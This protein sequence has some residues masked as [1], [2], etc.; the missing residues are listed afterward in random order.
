MGFFE[1]YREKKKFKNNLMI[2]RIRDKPLQEHVMSIIYSNQNN[3]MNL[4]VVERS[5]DIILWPGMKQYG[6]MGIRENKEPLYDILKITRETLAPTTNEITFQKAI[7]NIEYTKELSFNLKDEFLNISSKVFL[8]EM[9]DYV[10]RSCRGYKNSTIKNVY[11]IQLKELFEQIQKTRIYHPEI[12]NSVQ[13]HYAHL[14]WYDKVH[15]ELLRKFH[16]GKKNPY[17]FE[18][19]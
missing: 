4:L 18:L 12:A 13:P 6:T 7:K 11:Y 10:L 15:L 1:R 8:I 14:L 9:D 17:L 3:E 19:F 16:K 2:A 5:N